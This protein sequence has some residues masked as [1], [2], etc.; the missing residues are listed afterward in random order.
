MKIKL[1]KPSEWGFFINPETF[2]IYELVG[3]IPNNSLVIINKK[4]YRNELGRNIILTNY[5]LVSR[6][7]LDYL[8]K[9]DMEKRLAKY[10]STYILEKKSIPP[11]VTILK[12]LVDNKPVELVFVF[13]KNQNFTLKISEELLEGKNPKRI[14]EEIVTSSDEEYYKVN[15]E[16]RWKVEYAPNSRALCKRCKKQIKSKEIRLCEIQTIE[17]ILKK[18][19]YHFRCFEW[20]KVNR[21]LV[22]GIESLKEIDQNQINKKLKKP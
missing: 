22:F 16:E 3:E 13:R 12:K 8:S 6:N 17:D 7:K 5:A 19:Y 14:I 9:K 4:E 21:N 11:R 15:E 1:S 10:C 2:E 20:A 18:R